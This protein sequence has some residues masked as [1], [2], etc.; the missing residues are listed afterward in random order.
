MMPRRMASRDGAGSCARRAIR[1][2][3][4]AY[5]LTGSVSLPALAQP[6]PPPSAGPDAPV[7]SRTLPD[8]V[9]ASVEGHPIFLSD[10]GEAQAL[11]GRSRRHENEAGCLIAGHAKQ[12]MKPAN[13]ISARSMRGI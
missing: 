2:A 1:I 8:P 11:P 10:L 13:S 9:V 3:L 5:L 7:P 4:R 6:A 12:G